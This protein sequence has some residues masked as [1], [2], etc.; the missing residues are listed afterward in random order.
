VVSEEGIF[1][2]GANS[3]QLA[4]FIH[5]ELFDG[6]RLPAAFTQ[7]HLSPTAAFRA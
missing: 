4:H 7:L 2:S 3:A 1:A 6:P 5:P